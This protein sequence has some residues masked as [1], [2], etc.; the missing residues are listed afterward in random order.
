GHAPA[1]LQPVCV[2][3]HPQARPRGLSSS[4]FLG[5]IVRE[6]PPSVPC[7]GVWMAKAACLVLGEHGRLARALREALEHAPSLAARYAALMSRIL[8]LSAP[9]GAA[10]ST[11]SP[12]LRPMIALPTGDSFE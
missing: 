2:G 8:N 11:T 5:R 4:R 12:F 9:R 6:A 10:T 3:P 7:A 1:A